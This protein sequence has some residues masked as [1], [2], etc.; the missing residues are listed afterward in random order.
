MA[1]RVCA[2]CGGSITVKPGYRGPVVKFC[3]APC[4]KAFN[5]R[6]MTRGAE[7]YDILMSGRFERA[8]HAGSWRPLM[9][10]IATHYRDKD[11]AER[12]G[13]QSWHTPDLLGDPRAYNNS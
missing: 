13:R 5:N 11:K 4:R 12:D 9:T 8:T 1:N 3:S 2:E 10:Q 6:R 7:L